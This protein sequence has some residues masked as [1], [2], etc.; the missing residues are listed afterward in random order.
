MEIKEIIIIFFAF[1]V[2]AFS[3]PYVVKLVDGAV[4]CLSDAISS[5]VTAY[6][7]EWQNCIKTFK[8]WFYNGN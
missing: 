7:E 1:C 5:A 4:D 8:G 3:F 2:T 6:K